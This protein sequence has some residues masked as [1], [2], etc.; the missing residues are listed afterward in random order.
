MSLQVKAVSNS[1]GHEHNGERGTGTLENIAGSTNEDGVF[2]TSFT[3]PQIAG[4]EWIVASSPQATNKDSAEI[5]IAVSE[6]E[7]FSTLETNKWR[8]TG[9]A[10][11]TTYGKCSGEPILHPQ[12]HYIKTIMYIK[13]KIALEQFFHWT[14][15]DEAIG[16]YFTPGINDMSLPNGGIFDICSDWE[17]GHASHRNGIDVDIDSYLLELNNNTSLNMRSQKNQFL[18]DK[19]V[20][21]MEQNS[22]Y[23]KPSEG[24]HFRYEH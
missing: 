19:L 5:V 24:F 23:W 2:T 17:P 13:L 11:T 18:L 1:G 20:E 6:L 21:I 15:T 16:K 12:N 8:L 3:S 7:D 4:K 22:L 10:G 9:N 14:K